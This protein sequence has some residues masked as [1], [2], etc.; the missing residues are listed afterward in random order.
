MHVHGYQEEGTITT[1]FDM[2]VRNKIDRYHIALD[3]IKYVQN[4]N[5]DKLREYCENMLK[6]HEEYIRE[7]GVDMPEIE[8]FKLKTKNTD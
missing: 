7:Y 1:P 8:N 6:K 3:V 5:N 2:R 4:E